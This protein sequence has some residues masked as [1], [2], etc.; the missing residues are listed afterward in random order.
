MLLNSFAELL[1]ERGV[2]LRFTYGD[3]GGMAA[4]LQGEKPYELVLTAE[5]IYAED[6]VAALTDVLRAVNRSRPADAP[7]P[8]R[9]ASL[10]DSLDALNV[11]DEWAQRPL[12]GSDSV[13]LV[14]AKVRPPNQVLT[15]PTRRG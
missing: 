4:Q 2:E 6:S 13:I 1:E 8:E 7:A 10:E 11:K 12:A 5:T 9:S 15:V 14:A 3:W